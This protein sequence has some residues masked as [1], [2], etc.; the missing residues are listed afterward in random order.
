MLL[1]F[2]GA[3]HV[4]K[5]DKEIVLNGERYTISYLR[6]YAQGCSRMVLYTT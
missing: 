6:A 2:G 1:T 5:L 3:L 4:E